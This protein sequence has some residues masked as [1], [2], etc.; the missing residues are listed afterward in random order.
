MESYVREVTFTPATPDYLGL[1]HKTVS[2]Q[3]GLTRE[4][5]QTLIS[6]ARAWLRDIRDRR[7]GLR[8]RATP[9][10]AGPAR[11]R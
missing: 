8:A 7:F 9:F 3:A 4:Q 6:S 11:P 1:W 2:A 5:L 10:Q